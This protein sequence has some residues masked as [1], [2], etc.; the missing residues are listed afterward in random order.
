MHTLVYEGAEKGLSKEYNLYALIEELAPEI[1][2]EKRKMYKGVSANVDFY[3]GF[4]YDMLGIPRDLYTPLFAVGR[5]VSWC[6]HRMEEIFELCDRITVLRDGTYVD[7]RYIKDIN[8]DDIVQMM[9]GR[10]IGERFPKR[11]VKIGEEVLRVEGLTHEKLF[12][13]VSFL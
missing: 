8:M 3:S 1:I 7:T 6:A 9:I 4:V 12:K 11:D 2:A 5:C 13:N 10:T